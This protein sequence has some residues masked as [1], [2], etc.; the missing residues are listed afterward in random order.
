MTTSPA[1]PPPPWRGERPAAF[2]GMPAW[3]MATSRRSLEEFQVSRLEEVD[4]EWAW[5]GSDGSGVRVCVVDTGVDGAHPLVAGLARSLVVTQ[6]GAPTDEVTAGAANA[7]PAPAAGA[8]GGGGRDGTAAV[9]DCEPTDPAGHGTACAGIIRSIAPAVEIT[10]VRVLTDG[11][12]GS[13]AALLAGLRWAVDEGFDVVNLSL[14]TTRG[15]FQ[16]PLR[17]LADRAYFRRSLL[18]A[19]AH[20]MPVLSYPWTFSSVIS[21]ASHDESDPMTYYY[22]PAPPAEFYA[23]GVRVPV[24]WPGG[25]QL[26]STGNSFAAPHITGVCALILSKHPWLTPFQLKSVLYLAANNVTAS[27]GATH[28]RT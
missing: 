26:R 17:E 24:A 28:G 20:N 13:G 27:P 23:R 4:R 14:S 22:N 9:V 3:G 2:P 18:V 12:S 11:R 1:P 21:V 16:G 25:R 8:L 6:A 19:A 15:E 7:G 10:S 5:G